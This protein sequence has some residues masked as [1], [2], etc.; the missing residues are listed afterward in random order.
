[1]ISILVVLVCVS[2][3]LTTSPVVVSGALESPVHSAI[4]QLIRSAA[5]EQRIQRDEAHRIIQHARTQTRPQIAQIGTNRQRLEAFVSVVHRLAY[6]LWRS[7][8]HTNDTKGPRYLQSTQ[9]VIQQ[10]YDGLQPA[11]KASRLVQYYRNAQIDTLKSHLQSVAGELESREADALADIAS[12]L[13]HVRSLFEARVREC[14]PQKS[15]FYQQQLDAWLVTTFDV[16][17]DTMRAY[18][19]ALDQLLLRTERR[20][21]VLVRAA[22]EIAI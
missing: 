1:M 12:G 22:E 10:W 20:W 17:D 21:H 3:T 9:Q 14:N 8:R 6:E 2:L 4:A 15:R 5:A 16:L 18:S 11:Q 7:R 19:D 13:Q